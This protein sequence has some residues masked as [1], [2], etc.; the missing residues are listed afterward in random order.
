MMSRLNPL[1]A[2]ALAT[3]ALGAGSAQATLITLT[4]TDFDLTYDD[5]K[6]GLFGAP[7][8]TGD[9][10]SFT[11]NNF[12]AQSL[13]GTGF[14]TTNSTISGM[15]IDA[16]NGFVFGSLLLA[17]FGDYTLI[18]ALSSVNVAGQLRA[19]DVG[20]M[21]D[22]SLFTQTASNLVVNPATPLGIIDGANH[23]WQA[24]A[25]IDNT[26]PVTPPLFGTA[27]NGWLVAADKV[28]LTIENRLSAFTAPGQPFAQ[29]AFIEKKFAGVAITVMPVPEP[30]ALAALL[31]GF[32]LVGWARA[33]RRS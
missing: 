4:G 7:T 30:S 12:L 18:G 1:M 23:D 16:K 32:G 17:E 2:A 20:S 5:T 24:S 14:A 9:T 8:L 25:L 22:K 33:R 21:P 11:F 6:L 31:G 27:Q 19:F 13:N 15:V 29:L 26:T 28:G 10:I 3:L